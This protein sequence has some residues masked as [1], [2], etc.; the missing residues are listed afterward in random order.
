MGIGVIITMGLTSLACKL[1]SDLA[2]ASGKSTHA[3]II[4]LASMGILI[5]TAVSC[6]GE[7]LLSL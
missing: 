2:N 7:A 5:S 3:Q 4:E 1:V 6:I